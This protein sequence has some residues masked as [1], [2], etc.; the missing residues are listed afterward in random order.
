M[1]HICQLE[2]RAALHAEVKHKNPFLR[3]IAIPPIHTSSQAFRACDKSWALFFFFFFLR[4]IQLETPTN[5]GYH[6]SSFYHILGYFTLDLHT[7]TLLHC[8]LVFLVLV[9]SI[10]AFSFSI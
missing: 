9:F 5:S 10:L 7:I 6:K 1:E 8:I 3:T 4:D 2:Q